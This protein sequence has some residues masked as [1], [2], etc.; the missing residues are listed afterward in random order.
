[1]NLTLHEGIQLLD[2]DV[3]LATPDEQVVVNLTRVLDAAYRRGRY[4]RALDYGLP[5]DLPLDDAKRAWVAERVQSSPV[6]GGGAS[7]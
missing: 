6:S 3:E 7:C 1:M 4:E 2:Q 5:L